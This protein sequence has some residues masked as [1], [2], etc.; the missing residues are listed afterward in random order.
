MNYD[1]IEL[2]HLAERIRLLRR[3]IDEAVSLPEVPRHALVGRAE[4]IAN[5]DIRAARLAASF[6]PLLDRDIIGDY[7]R[8]Q[9]HE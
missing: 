5:G 2:S 3:C 1:N 4:T 6:R 7:A 8:R 9:N